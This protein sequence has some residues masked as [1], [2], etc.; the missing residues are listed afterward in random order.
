M[1]ALVFGGVIV[2]KQKDFFLHAKKLPFKAKTYI[3][4]AMPIFLVFSVKIARKIDIFLFIEMKAVIGLTKGIASFVYSNTTT[5][6]FL[7][8]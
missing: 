2:T 3:D 8:F 4:I 6:I 7:F 1:G 5:G